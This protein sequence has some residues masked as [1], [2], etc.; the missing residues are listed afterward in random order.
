MT[1]KEFLE[2]VA[3]KGWPKIYR[4]EGWLVAR[5]KDG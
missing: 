1:L 4:G 5:W 2:I 3:E